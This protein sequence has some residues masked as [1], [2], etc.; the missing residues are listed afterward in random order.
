MCLFFSRLLTIK[1]SIKFNKMRF[2]WTHSPLKSYTIF[3]IFIL[4]DIIMAEII[5]DDNLHRINRKISLLNMEDHANLYKA[6]TMEHEKLQHEDSIKSAASFQTRSSSWVRTHTG[7]KDLTQIVKSSKWNWAGH[8]SRRT[9]DRWTTKSTMWITD[10]GGRKRGK[11]TPTSYIYRIRS[12]SKKRKSIAKAGQFMQTL[13]KK[14]SQLLNVEPSELVIQTSGNLS[15][16]IVHQQGIV[17]HCVI[18]ENC[19]GIGRERYRRLD[20]SCNNMQH[21]KDCKNE[22]L[23][24]SRTISQAV[25]TDKNKPHARISH[26]L[27]QFGQFV[28]HDLVLVPVATVG[29][30]GC[31]RPVQCCY[32]DGSRPLERS[33]QH[34]HCLPIEIDTTDPFFYKL[35]KQGCLEFVR[36]LASPDSTC[37]FKWRE[38][39]S[40]VTHFLDGSTIYGSSVEINNKLR[41]HS[42]GDE[43]VNEQPGLS[44]MHTVFLREHNRIADVLAHNHPFWN[45]QTIF[46]E[47]RRIVVAIIQK[48]VYSDF[49]PLVVGF[50]QMVKYDLLF[51]PASHYNPDVDPSIMNV[52][53]T[54]AFR[55]GHSLI[56]NDFILKPA[57]SDEQEDSIKLRNTFFRPFI[58][59]SNTDLDKYLRGLSV[60]PSQ[61][62]DMFMVHSVTRHLYQQVT[63]TQS[64]PKFGSDLAAL[65]IQ[66]G[67]DH[68][69]PPYNQW[70]IKC[71]LPRVSSWKQLATYVSSVQI[72]DQLKKVYKCPDDIDIFVGGLLET[73]VKGGLVGSTFSCIISEQFRR[74]Y[75]GDRFFYTHTAPH[76]IGFTRLIEFFLNA[77]VVNIEVMNKVET[78]ITIRSRENNKI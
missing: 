48:I 34:S 44:A 14:Y 16:R 39:F 43:R 33:L 37:N 73:P 28:D 51:T 4:I 75:R 55:F 35:N 45:D 2:E 58:L 47:A 27:M 78:S 15:Y 36:S 74:L 20:G 17:D 23:K 12:S 67:R 24:S 72:I 63:A 62:V 71:G 5:E 77:K 60:Q 46:E 49:L 76:H 52:F 64:N 30:E 50:Q 19:H 18:F 68:G 54:A 56:Q 6:A 11:L 70:R 29:E 38:Q 21:H 69:L 59:Q 40:E 31:E 13:A 57:D 32:D 66:R 10:R 61:T 7:C 41:T 3:F 1:F 53:S 65:N 26:F 9:G 25:F 42:F 22:M 8:L